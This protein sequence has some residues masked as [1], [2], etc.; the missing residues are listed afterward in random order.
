MQWRLRWWSLLMGWGPLWQISLRVGTARQKD[1][2]E[3]QS[4]RLTAK[5]T[6]NMYL[7]KGRDQVPKTEGKKCLRSG[8]TFASQRHKKRNASFSWKG[9]CSFKVRILKRCFIKPGFVCLFVFKLCTQLI[10]KLILECQKE[11]P[12]NLTTFRARFPLIPN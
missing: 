7:P 11:N 5:H 10:K 8:R 6:L 4:I 9:F 2:S 3:S 12:N 1:C